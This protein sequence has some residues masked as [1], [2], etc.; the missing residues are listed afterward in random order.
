M[1]ATFFCLAGAHFSE[2]QR[3]PHFCE[4]TILP[5]ELLNIGGA[6]GGGY[7]FDDAVALAAYDGAAD[8][9]LGYQN[10]MDA[11]PNRDSTSTK[12]PSVSHVRKSFPEVTLFWVTSR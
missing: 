4:C 9:G 1:I 12:A 6:V 3:A 8:S 10:E 11:T 7:Y 2:W 5:I